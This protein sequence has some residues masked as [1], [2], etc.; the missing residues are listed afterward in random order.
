MHASGPSI[1]GKPVLFGLQH[2]LNSLQFRFFKFEG[3]EKTLK[4]FSS[5]IHE[6]LYTPICYDADQK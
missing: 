2:F 1:W 5:D 3:A 4:F 6:N